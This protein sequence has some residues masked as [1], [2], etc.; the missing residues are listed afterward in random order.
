MKHIAVT[1]TAPGGA[2]QTYSALFESTTAALL[3]ALDRAPCERCG[4]SARLVRP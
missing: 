1:I 4:V 2:Q 3:D